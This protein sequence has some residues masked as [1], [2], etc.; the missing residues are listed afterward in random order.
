MMRGDLRYVSVLKLQT[1]RGEGIMRVCVAVCSFDLLGVLPSSG[2]D[3]LS[4]H[5]SAQKNV[6]V[7]EEWL[8]KIAL[9]TDDL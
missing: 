4:S 6:P 3:I 5:A 1:D 8:R 9:D 7:N 2:L